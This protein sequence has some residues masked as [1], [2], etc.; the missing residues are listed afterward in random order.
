MAKYPLQICCDHCK[1]VVILVWEPIPGDTKLS[2][3]FPLLDT[4]FSV[5]DKV[6]RCSVCGKHSCA[7]TSTLV[8]PL[9]FIGKIVKAEK[10][11]NGTA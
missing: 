7:E 4:P 10:S 1:E 8:N 5:H 2:K 9:G 6:G 3:I 11:E